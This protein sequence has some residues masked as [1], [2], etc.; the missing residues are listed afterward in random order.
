MHKDGDPRGGRSA[1]REANMFASA[2]LMPSNDVRSRIPRSVTA[3]IIVKAKTRWRVSAMALA[4]RL[5]HLGI[6]SEWNYKSLCVELGKRGFRSAEPGGIE[7]ETSKIWRK[8]LSELWAE[9]ITKSTIADNLS[10]P[11]DEL[12][13]LIWNLTGTFERPERSK[14]SFLSAVG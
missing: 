2:F 9:R 11:L 7:R 13:G 10:L 14:G 4:Y 5:N 8:V 6:L 3:D 12:E 1:E